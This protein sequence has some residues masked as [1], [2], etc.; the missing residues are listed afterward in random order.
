[1]IYFDFL[2]RYS[3]R[4]GAVNGGEGRE[5][6]HALTAFQL[7]NGWQWWNVQPFR[8]EGLCHDSKTGKLH[9]YSTHVEKRHRL[10]WS[11]YT[12]GPEVD[13]H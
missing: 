9:R 4:L 2:K 13:P 8:D 12:I 10:N 1:M 3:I 7:A 6:I 5:G 11:I